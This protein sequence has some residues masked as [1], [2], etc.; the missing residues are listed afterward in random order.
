MRCFLISFAWDKK[1]FV[2]WAL[3]ERHRPES[4]AARRVKAHIKPDGRAGGDGSASS[5]STGGAGPS[6]DLE[7][8]L[9]ATFDQLDGT[10][11]E[12]RDEAGQTSSKGVVQ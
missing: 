8:A 10:W 9:R 3:P 2:F 7:H 1:I 6:D 12:C 11:R 4:C 5:S